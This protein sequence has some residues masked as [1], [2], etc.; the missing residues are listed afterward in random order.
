MIKRLTEIDITQVE[1]LLNHQPIENLFILGC[2]EASRYQQKPLTGW[3][4]F[5]Q[6]GEL[7]AVLWQ[8]NTRFIPFAVEDFD[9]KGVAHIIN[10]DS[11]SSMLFGLRSIVTK[12]APFLNQLTNRSDDLYFAISSEHQRPIIN[13]EDHVCKLTPSDLN[14]LER[15]LDQI[16]EFQRSTA[17]ID[18]KREDLKTGISRGYYLKEK[19]QMVTTASTT[20]ENADS[21]MLSGVATH[22]DFTGRGLASTCVSKLTEDILLEGKSLYLFYDNLIAGKLY[23]KL[24]FLHVGDWVM[25]QSIN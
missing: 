23:K 12:I 2:L 10:T 1:S 6:N 13:K 20:L 8:S 15:L 18:K 5:D 19:G 17:R 21:A 9:A 24:G 7:H 14:L 11:N 4:D 25:Y 3:G 16:P 22:P